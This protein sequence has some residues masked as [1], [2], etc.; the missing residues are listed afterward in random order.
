MYGRNKS[1]SDDL[2]MMTAYVFVDARKLLNLKAY[3]NSNT[4]ST[5]IRVNDEE[6]QLDALE[7][8][9]TTLDLGFHKLEVFSGKSTEVD[10]KGFIIE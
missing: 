7:K 10:F 6:Y 8:T 1:I 9:I 2:K 5:Y 4:S 3:K